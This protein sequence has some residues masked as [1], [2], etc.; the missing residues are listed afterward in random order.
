MCYHQISNVTTVVRARPQY[1]YIYVN[2]MMSLA[3][4]L[5]SMI[6]RRAVHRA[7]I[8]FTTHCV[9]TWYVCAEL[10]NRCIELWR[11]YSVGGTQC[12]LQCSIVPLECGPSKHNYAVKFQM[13]VKQASYQCLLSNAS[14]SS[15]ITQSNCKCGS[16]KHR[17]TVYFQMRVNQAS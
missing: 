4:R 11:H 10:Q 7:Q 8:Q 9:N 5:I 6:S 15:I 14:Q 13:R 2:H 16:T 12:G 1:Y 3:T 17:T